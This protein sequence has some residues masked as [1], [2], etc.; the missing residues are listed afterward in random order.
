MARS[1]VGESR[2]EGSST[3]CRTR[4]MNC[5]SVIPM[6]LRRPETRSIELYQHQPDPTCHSVSVS[7]HMA[8]RVMRY[9]SM[10]L[11]V[12]VSTGDV[13]SQLVSAILWSHSIPLTVSTP[14]KSPSPATSSGRTHRPNLQPK[15]RHGTS[16]HGAP[17]NGLPESARSPGQSRR[18]S[19]TASATRMS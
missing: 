14:A 18:R 1:P 15:F 16:G 19:C 2:R 8:T 13:D 5:H 17:E 12:C 11:A 9:G 6:P 3:I 10:C 4:S 7:Y